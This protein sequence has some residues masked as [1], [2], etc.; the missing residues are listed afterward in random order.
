MSR[1]HKLDLRE[2]EVSPDGRYVRFEEKL[3]SG[4][5]KEVYLCYDT[6][7]GKECAWNTVQLGRIPESEKRRI[8]METEILAS[9][10]HPHIIN[11]YHVWENPQLDQICLT[12]DHRVLTRRGWRS[13]THVQEGEEVLSFNV[14]S[15]QQE[16]KPVVAVVSH[17]VRRSMKKEKGKEEAE[18]DTLYRMQGANMDVIVTRDHRNLV[19]RLVTTGTG[20]QT[21]NKAVDY[22]TVP[23]LQRLS[24]SQSRAV[25]CGGPSPQPPVKIVIPGLTQVCEWWWQRDSQREFLQFVGFW[26]GD[27]FLDSANGYVSIIQKKERSR[28]WLEQLLGVVFPGWWRINRNSRDQQQCV[29]NIR[30]PPLYSYLQVMAVGPTGYNLR[31]PKQLRVYPHF[32]Y[33]AGLAEEE[34]KSAY[35]TRN[36]SSNHI[37]T[38][39]ENEMLAAFLHATAA[40]SPPSQLKYVDWTQ[41]VSGGPDWEEVAEW[42]EAPDW[43]HTANWED[44]EEEVNEPLAKWSAAEYDAA[45]EDD[46]VDED[47]VPQ[48]KEVVDEDGETVRTPRAEAVVDEQGDGKIGEALRAKGKICWYYQS[49]PVLPVPVAV[50]S[51]DGNG[52]WI[53]LNGHWFYLKRW[54]GDAQ[55]IA[56]VYSRLSRE[57][58]IALLDGFCR[59]DGWCSTIRYQDDD[60]DTAPHE[61]TGKWRCSSSSFPLIDHLMLIGQ[62]A[63]AAVD[64]CLHTK[65]GIVSTNGCPTVHTQR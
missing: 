51:V 50:N 52:W 24:H 41:Y 25:V 57:Q 48:L 42:A 33:D 61:P 27:G 12:G 5:Y 2:V 4:A 46:A 40:P 3:G 49:G 28:E 56:D 36:S 17:A 18:A 64:V 6:E 63:G 35:Y 47:D 8:I 54:L 23:D 32:T 37:S 65:A 44:D 58:A 7:T 19:A 14:D 29:Y 59:A 20:L 22:E 1:S 39:T 21:R 10:H 34:Q 15:Y 26:L 9:L 45:G 16:W 55:Q 43:E 38:W 30:C 31:D 62:L 60:D 13:I 11:F 53:I